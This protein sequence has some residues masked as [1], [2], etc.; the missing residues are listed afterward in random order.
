MKIGHCT[1]SLATQVLYSGTA[2]G[3]GQAFWF[4]TLTNALQSMPTTVGWVILGA[5]H[6]EIETAVPP[7]PTGEHKNGPGQQFELSPNLGDGRAG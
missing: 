7:I 6:V 1:G 4:G 5:G 3:W 2:S